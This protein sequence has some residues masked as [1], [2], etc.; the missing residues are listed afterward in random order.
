MYVFKLGIVPQQS[1]IF[2][3]GFSNANN[4]YRKSDKCTKA[5][6][7]IIL[8]NTRHHYYLNPNINRSNFDTAKP[9]GSYYFKVN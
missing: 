1:G 9:N 7:Q 2:G 8:E 5:N 4:V 3:I 6:F